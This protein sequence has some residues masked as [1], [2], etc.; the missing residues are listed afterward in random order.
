MIA[1]SIILWALVLIFIAFIY[2]VH[3]VE[4][5]RLKT[6]RI[7][8]QIE[9]IPPELQD[10]RIAMFSDTHV[11]DHAGAV[12]VAR[13]A[14]RRVMKESPDIILIAGDVAHR[15]YYL[16]EAA[17]VLEPLQ[18]PYGV[19][20][21]FGNH[22]RDFTL[23]LPRTKPTPDV[24]SMDAWMDTMDDI[25]INLL[26]NTPH[27]L[28]IGGKNMLIVGVGDPSCGLDDL[29]GAL[30]GAPDADLKILL[31]HSPDIF[32][33]PQAQW[34]D[35]ILCGHTHG[36]QIQIPGIGS[37]WAPV[38]RDRRRASGVMRLG[39]NT[40]AY[41]SR[42]VGSGTMA[43]FNCPPEIAIL[44]TTAGRAEDVRQINPLPVSR[45]RNVNVDGAKRLEA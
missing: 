9:T 27:E 10:L 45:C 30:E 6:E 14:V 3:W 7:D 38:W 16:Q 44:T 29:D 36:G 18:A 43:R 40:M 22:D 32:D 35:L 26:H 34:A 13:E 28:V 23:G 37:P 21:V 20:M 1:T 24:V 4:P 15:S 11:R 17:E 39:D 12:N 8:I 31:A 19:Y 33:H 2:Y 5:V 41:V 42:G 25:G